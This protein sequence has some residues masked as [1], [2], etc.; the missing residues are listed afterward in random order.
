VKNKLP[1]FA[2]GLALLI[3]SIVIAQTPS[4]PPAARSASAEGNHNVAVLDLVRIFNEC[5]QITD[6]NQLIRE[7]SDAFAKEA[8]QRR[9]VIEDKQMELQAFKTGSPDWEARRK[10]LV[11][12]NID[13][14]VWLKVT[15]QQVDQ[16]KF[17]WTRIIYEQ[18]VQV[19][20][21]LAKERGYVAVLQRT[22]FKPL[23]IEPTVQNLR[24]VI[25]ERAVVYNTAEIDI[26]ELV[27]RKMDADYKAAG[28]KKVLGSP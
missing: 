2:L 27:I 11:R 1:I 13:A 22:E 20:S 4:Q 3:G 17:D 25:Q 24:R 5:A 10:D 9:K 15:E 23:E 28:G 18:A 26:T 16:E 21:N 19:A 7:K 6:L 8:T 12:L 14:N